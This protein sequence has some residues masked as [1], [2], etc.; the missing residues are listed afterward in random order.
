MK[1]DK[2]ILNDFLTYDNFEYDFED[3]PLL[4]QGKNLTDKNQASNGSGKSGIQAGIEF[5]IT[6]SNSRGVRDSELVSFW[7]KE[8]RAQLFA[9]CNVRKE[10]IHIDWTIKVKGSNQVNIRIKKHD[11]NQWAD[12]CFSNVNDG[13]KYIES[14]FAISKEDLF[15]YY[16]INK[17]RFKSFFN[18][19]N[20]QKV[21][22]INRF[23][24]AS[25]IE[26]I[27]KIDN[28]KLQSEHDILENDI[29]KID[30]KIEI[31]EQRIITEKG[32]D[33]KAEMAEDLEDLED[34]IEDIEGKINKVKEEITEEETSK[35][36]LPDDI[37]EINKK[38]KELKGEKYGL[39][40]DLKVESKL[41][42]GVESKLS[43]AQEL[44]KE[45]VS[46]DW[47]EERK[48]YKHQI[49]IEDEKIVKSEF[50]K[51]TEAEQESQILKFL[52][53][54][55]IKLQGS[56]ICPS[57]SH[58][59]VLDGDIDEL[60]KKKLKGESL[61]KAIQGN[62]KTTEITRKG[63]DG[64]IED[65][66]ALL[67]RINENEERENKSKNKLIDAVNSIKKKVSEHKEEELEIKEDIRDLD[68][69][70]TKLKKEIDSLKLEGDKIDIEIESLNS[71]ITNHKA[72]IDIY[73]GQ[74]KSMKLGSNKD[75]IKELSQEIKN[76]KKE[77]GEESDELQKVGDKI[78]ERNQWASN[79]KQFRMFLANQS[80]EVIEFHCN[81]YLH[82]MDSDLKVKL[83]GYKMLAN[84]TTKDE[85]TAKIVRDNERSFHSFS[86]G[87]QGRL[88][89]T[90]IL[91]NRHMIN[92]THPYGGLDFLSVDEV[93]E[94]VDAIGLRHLVDAAKEL[95][96]SVMIITHVTSET[97]DDNILLVTKENGVS[98]I[99]R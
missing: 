29:A 23:S 77:R 67:S 13:K 81:R 73:Q 94:G 20:K 46:T 27:E 89:F 11:E 19:S 1:L 44:V 75:V 41:L 8:S 61:K 50:I 12:V 49:T 87:E 90:S 56:I 82:G 68:E 96:I 2:L 72:E 74:I 93:F 26:G 18:S 86:G 28:T 80:L 32:R 54:I 17:T 83:E 40:E 53:D 55:D 5:C 66:Q 6:A 51:E 45:F 33:F 76:L 34:E 48:I 47:D 4:V 63:I 69:K 30:G 65:I 60:E 22:L 58:E 21:D 42:E 88:L 38:I 59:F 16:I 39:E 35:E 14:W 91:A 71:K 85:I 98:K 10:S 52:Q 62:Q 31:T 57:C 92:N 3:K 25:I 7:A 79:F 37:E 70:I 97:I 24:D 36:N 64:K 43:T 99:K 84:G 9:S 78:Y 15:N 95:Q